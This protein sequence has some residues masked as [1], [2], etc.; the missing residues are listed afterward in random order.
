[1][2]LKNCWYVAADAHEVDRTPF[3]RTI[4]GENV[5]FWRRED[6]APVAF[7]DRCC[8]RRMPLRKGRLIGDVLRCHYHGLEF[9]ASGQCIHIP[10]QTTI[11]PGAQVRTYP[12]VE[13][14]RWIWIWMGDP[15]LADDSKIV[16]YPWKDHDDWGDKGTY[17]HVKGDYKLIV[18]NLLDLSHLA[19][20]HE[21]TIGNA[22]VAENAETRTLKDDESVT[23]ARWTVGQPPPPTYQK[24]GGWEPDRIVDRWQIIE[25]RPPGAVRLFTGA[26]PDAAEG[27]EFGFTDLERETPAGGFGFHNLNFVTPETETSCHYF[28]SNAHDVKPITD[29]ITDLQYRQIRTAFYQDWEVFELQ[30]RNWDD[31]PVIDLNVDAGPIAARALIDRRLAEQ[32]QRN[33]VAAAE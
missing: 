22:A 10:K 30:E 2:F 28:W 12:V 27:K 1:M 20:V 3:G 14:Y 19:Y 25:F 5:V 31:R 13:R 16:P 11:P 17:F 21:S 33:R 4:C 26:A 9:D 7:E 18:D 15:A 6:G 8:H 24:M 29:E 32:A 23:V